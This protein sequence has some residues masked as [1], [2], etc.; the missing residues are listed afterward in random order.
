M[1]QAHGQRG[2]V[3]IYAPLTPTGEPMSPRC[4]ACTICVEYCPVGAITGEAFR[5][6]DSLDIRFNA[7]KCDQYHV[8]LEKEEKEAICGI[9]LYVCPYGQRAAERIQTADT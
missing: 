4:G 7:R 2:T 6:T 3:L 8:S 1:M 9:C 5:T